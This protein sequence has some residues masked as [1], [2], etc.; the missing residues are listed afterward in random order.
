MALD[1][2]TKKMIN[3]KQNQYFK[4]LIYFLIISVLF[5]TTTCDIPDDD[6]PSLAMVIPPSDDMTYLMDK[7]FNEAKIDRM[8]WYLQW[9]AIE[10]TKG[11]YNWGDTDIFFNTLEYFGYKTAISIE[12]MCTFTGNMS[13]IPEDLSFSKFD[14][15]EFI[16][17]YKNFLDKFLERYSDGI[18][19]LYLT[20]EIDSYF[21][22]HPEETDALSEYCNMLN[23]II[24]FLR[25]KYPDTKIGTVCS[26]H[27]CFN[28]NRLDIPTEI[29]KHVDIMGYSLYHVDHEAQFYGNPSDIRNWLS[30]I[31]RISGTTPIAITET[32]WPAK[33]D[34]DLFYEDQENEQVLYVEEVFK[35]KDIFGD[36]LKYVT[37]Y[38]CTDY[39]IQEVIDWGLDWTMFTGLIRGFDSSSREER[40]SWEKW[41]ELVQKD[42]DK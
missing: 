41:I 38:S 32:T 8:Y 36:N 20:N 3:M 1:M 37:W 2:L 30:E 9:N 35:M 18:E 31:Q 6:Y 25:N 40:K 26:F 27:N 21:H 17:T 11:I 4:S 19:Y 24:P 12:P 5:S 10:E 22:A 39:H 15:S 16:D 29:A 23:A 7:A 14:N 33:T 13:Y 42:Q 28:N 34:I